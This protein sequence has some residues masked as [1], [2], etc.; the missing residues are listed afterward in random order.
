[1]SFRNVGAVDGWVF[2]CTKQA[3]GQAY[4]LFPFAAIRQ[5][6]SLHG[7]FELPVDERAGNL[8]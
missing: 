7:L 5:H 3:V 2:R 8:E 1:M 4:S 6:G